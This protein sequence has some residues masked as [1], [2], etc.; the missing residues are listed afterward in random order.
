MRKIS[1]EK[2]RVGLVWILFFTVVYF[3]ITNSVRY[4]INGLLGAIGLYIWSITFFTFLPSPGK[5][6]EKCER[7]FKTWTYTL[8]PTLIWF[9][10]TLLF[11]FLLPPPRTTSIWGKS[12]SIIYIAF[13][14]SLLIWKLIL[15]YLS[16]RFS[17]RIHLYRIIYYILVYLAIS[18]PLWLYL[19]SIGISRVPFV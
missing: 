5:I 7:M 8:L 12:F 3:F 16:I 17:L 11:Y 4:W 6:K 1:L 15:V 14:V 18:V 19:Y 2:N 9:Y 10:T 13:S